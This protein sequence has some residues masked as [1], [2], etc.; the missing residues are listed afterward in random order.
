MVSASTIQSRVNS[1]VQGARGLSGAP[2]T[3]QQQNYTIANEDL[4]TQIAALR[5]LEAELTKLEQQLDAAGVPHT[6]G[7]RPGQ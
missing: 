5:T 7:R 4:T 1:A 2:T 6:P 3:T